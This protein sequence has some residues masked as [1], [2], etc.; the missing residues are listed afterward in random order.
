MPEFINEKNE[1]LQEVVSTGNLQIISQE[2]STING[3]EA[4]VTDAIGIFQTNDASFD[5]KFKETSISGIDKF[6][7]FVHYP[8]MY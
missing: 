3:K 1:L 2:K 6:Y 4:Y 8:Y 7:T 5:V